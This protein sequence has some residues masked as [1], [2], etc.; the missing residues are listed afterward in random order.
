M[1]EIRVKLLEKHQKK[2]DKEINE[3]ELVLDAAKFGAMHNGEDVGICV[4]LTRARDHLRQASYSML[5]AIASAE[6]QEL[7]GQMMAD[8]E[9]LQQASEE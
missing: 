7:T 1:E 4:Q 9:N 2:L 8:L 5:L 6:G 3:L